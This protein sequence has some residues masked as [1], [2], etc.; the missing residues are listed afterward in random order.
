MGIILKT[1]VSLKNLAF[2]ES[3]TKNSITPF[4]IQ[5][6]LLSPG[7]TLEVKITDFLTAIS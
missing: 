7:C 6:A 3:L 2:S 5:E 4:I 1:K